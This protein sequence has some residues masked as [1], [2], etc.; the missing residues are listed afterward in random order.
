MKIPEIGT[1]LKETLR[2]IRKIKWNVWVQ[3]PQNPAGI[4]EN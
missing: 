1:G 2:I 3:R 4:I